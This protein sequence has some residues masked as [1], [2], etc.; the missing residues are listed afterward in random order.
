MAYIKVTNKD[1][2]NQ[3][4]VDIELRDGVNSFRGDVEIDGNCITGEHG[5]NDYENDYGFVI[6]KGE[7]TESEVLTKRKARFNLNN[8][9]DF[10]HFRLH[11]IEQISESEKTWSDVDALHSLDYSSYFG[12]CIGDDNGLYDQADCQEDETRLVSGDQYD[13]AY[14]AFT[15]IMADSKED[16][17]Q[18]N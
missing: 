16:Y 10:D 12:P 7:N 9:K 4:D 6:L 15:K 2:F 17:F 11:C 14:E 5:K 13:Q 3:F 8:R 18:N 1:L